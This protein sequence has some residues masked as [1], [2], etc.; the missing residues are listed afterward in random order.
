M[1]ATLSFD[2]SAGPEP[3]ADVRDEIQTTIGT[4]EQCDLLSDVLICA[5]SDTDDYLALVKALRGVASDFPRQFQ[6]VITLHRSGEPLRS[7]GKFARDQ[8]SEI[9]DAEDEDQ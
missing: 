3:I 4:R 5:I 9:I 6:F 8:A 7:N 1:Y 2:V